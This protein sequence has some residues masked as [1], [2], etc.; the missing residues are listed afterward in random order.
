MAPL[1]GPRVQYSLGLDMNELVHMRHLS[2][3]GYVQC[4]T[5]FGYPHLTTSKGGR[6][7]GIEA[8]VLVLTT[9]WQ[10]MRSVT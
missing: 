8:K 3:L 9:A 1:C 6:V 10:L 7:L 2:A 4:L 5:G